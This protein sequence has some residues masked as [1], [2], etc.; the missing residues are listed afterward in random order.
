M[1]MRR[2]IE[3]HNEV[4]ASTLRGLVKNYSLHDSF[5]M[6]FTNLAFCRSPVANQRSTKL[7]KVM[8]SLF[9]AILVLV[10]LLLLLLML[11]LP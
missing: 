3:I 7:L 10:K 1:F 11:M 6:D 4:V 2:R 5:T 9:K 8:L